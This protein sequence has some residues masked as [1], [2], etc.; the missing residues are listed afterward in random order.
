MKYSIYLS[1]PIQA[2]LKGHKNRSGR[3]NSVIQRYYTIMKEDPE[4]AEWYEPEFAAREKEKQMTA[5][6]IPT[7]HLNGTSREE[8]MQ[9]L[10]TAIDAI[11]AAID[12][13]QKAAPHGRDYYPQGSEVIQ[14]AMTQHYHRLNRLEDVRRELQVIGEA[15]INGKEE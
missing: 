10:R 15:I 14:T 11:D 5:L 7:V 13:C 3:L 6:A 8:L 1:E 4:L 2:V 12:A 9:Q